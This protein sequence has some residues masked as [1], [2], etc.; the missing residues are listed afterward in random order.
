MGIGIS[1]EAL[2]SK[3]A[4]LPLVDF[5]PPKDVVG[6][7][8]VA[9]IQS[10]LYYGAI[11]MIDGILERVIEKLGPETKAIATGGQGE[12]ITHASRFVK[13]YDEDLTLEGLRLIWER[14]QSR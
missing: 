1:I 5:R 6:T 10:G 7:N 4:R 12:R 2:F 11:G 3:T 13:I 9:S 14:A 8:T